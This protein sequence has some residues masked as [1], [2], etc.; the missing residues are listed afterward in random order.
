MDE[1]QKEIEVFNYVKEN[2]DKFLQVIVQ[3]L[4]AGIHEENKKLREQKSKVEVGMVILAD[5]VKLDKIDTN[6]KSALI[7][8]IKSCTFIK[9][10]SLLEKLE[11]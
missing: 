3:G 6:L 11:K 7:D 2:A 8:G 10:D 4:V 1:V 5:R 9:V